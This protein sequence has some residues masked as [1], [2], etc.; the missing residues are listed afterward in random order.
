[1][2]LIGV[3]L[4]K[5]DDQSDQ[6]IVTYRYQ[7]GSEREAMVHAIKTGVRAD[8]LETVYKD[9][10]FPIDG[11]EHI[12]IMDEVEAEI[13]DDEPAIRFKGDAP[14]PYVIFS[15][16]RRGLLSLDT[17]YGVAYFFGSEVVRHLDLRLETIR[18]MSAWLKEQ[19]YIDEE[20]ASGTIFRH[21]TAPKTD[22]VDELVF[23]DDPAV[24]KKRKDRL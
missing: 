21:P 23:D 3:E 11:Y 10:V 15:S 6:W 5:Q 8:I 14:S 12:G 4:V 7:A 17:L 22:R 9:G 18:E 20:T 13:V 1:M 16:Y 2:K 19:G 24:V